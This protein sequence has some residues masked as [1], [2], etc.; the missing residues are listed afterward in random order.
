MDGEAM[1][2]AYAGSGFLGCGPE[3]TLTVLPLLRPEISRYAASTGERLGG[4]R[5]PRFRAARVSREGEMVIHRAPAEGVTDYAASLASLPDGRLLVQVGPVPRGARRHEFASL[6]SFLLSWDE[7][8]LRELGTSLPRIVA[9][10]GDTAI[11]VHTDPE[12]AVSRLPLSKVL[13]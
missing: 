7:S 2:S 10:R 13:R 3:E 6:R 4:M 5:I 12:P 9:I 1:L 8:T 11:A